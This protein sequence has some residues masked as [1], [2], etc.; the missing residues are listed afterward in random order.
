MPASPGD[1]AKTPRA[2]ASRPRER[3]ARSPGR[4]G[5]VFGK[6]SPQERPR[7]TSLGGSREVG[8]SSGPPEEEAEKAGPGTARR[9]RRLT[10]PVSGWVS[11]PEPPAGPESA[12]DCK[13]VNQSILKESSPGCFLEGPVLKLKL[14]PPDAQN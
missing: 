3:G 1:A 10:L 7:R 14:W 2:H 4:P 8:Q 5:N 11:A 6:N 13:E 12:L 9:P